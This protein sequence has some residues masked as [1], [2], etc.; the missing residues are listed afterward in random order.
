MGMFRYF[1]K[2]PL[3]SVVCVFLASTSLIF[4]ISSMKSSVKSYKIFKAEPGHYDRY[5]RSPDDLKFDL[6]KSLKE[7]GGKSDCNITIEDIKL[8]YEAK[9]ISGHTEN[10]PPICGADGCLQV[11]QN[12]PQ[13][14]HP[15]ISES[16]KIEMQAI[17]GSLNVVHVELAV[18]ITRIQSMKSIYGS[19]GEIRP[20]WGKYLA[21]LASVV[22]KDKKEQLFV[23]DILQHVDEKLN[24][25]IRASLENTLNKVGFSFQLG[26]KGSGVWLFEESS[27]YLSKYV[28]VK[29]NIPAFRLLALSATEGALNVLQDIRKM[30][31]VMRPGGILVIDYEKTNA[32]EKYITLYGPKVLVPLMNIENKLYVCTHQ[33]HKE[34]MKHFEKPELMKRFQL[35]KITDTVY[36]NEF[37]YLAKLEQKLYDK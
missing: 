1:K 28:F 35:T 23:G 9:C 29:M 22:I 7:L 24:S 11:L 5:K 20:S 8:E 3:A 2:N 31:C 33:Y 26:K 13:L 6:K 37:T 30:A 18:E 19:V 34:M 16:D 12:T 15:E 25:D 17:Q 27:L 4:L 21:A 14:T 36:G 32:F 10:M